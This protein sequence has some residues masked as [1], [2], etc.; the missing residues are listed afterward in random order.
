MFFTANEVSPLTA[1]RISRPSLRISRPSLS[2]QVLRH[3][4][5]HSTRRGK[6]PPAEVGQQLRALKPTGWAGFLTVCDRAACVWAPPPSPSLSVW[7]PPLGHRPRTP[8]A[9]YLGTDLAAS[10]PG[11]ARQRRHRYWR[12]GCLGALLHLRNQRLQRCCRRRW[13]WLRK[14]E[15]AVPKAAKDSP[16]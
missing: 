10:C 1:L 12:C 2:L 7:P 9:L 11:G 8:A 16:S 4:L 14:K 3:G 5:W 6:S 15:P 13:R